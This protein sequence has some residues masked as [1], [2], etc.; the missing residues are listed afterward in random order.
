MPVKALLIPQVPPLPPLKQNPLCSVYLFI[1]L[2]YLASN[3]NPKQLRV[4]KGL[5]SLQVTIHHWGKSGQELK[6]GSKADSR[7]LCS[8]WA[9]FPWL[10]QLPFWDSPG[11]PAQGWYHTVRL[12]LPH[13]SLN[14]TTGSADGDNSSWVE[15]ASSWV[16]VK[17]T[18]TDTKLY[19]QFMLSIYLSIF[20][21][22]K[23]C[24]L[25]QAAQSA[26]T[27]I[28]GARSS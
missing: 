19:F 17:S 28:P 5:F 7:G 18:K 13:Q 3:I 21:F 8:S 23:G 26:S 22:P 12:A 27:I 4:E 1:L 24:P 11:P 25:L 20:W 9:C 14:K 2:T 16:C 10:A 6:A 15:I